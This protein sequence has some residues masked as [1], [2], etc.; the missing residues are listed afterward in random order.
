MAR[1]QECHFDFLSR[2]CFV[3]SH[4]LI[5]ISPK[6]NC[7]PQRIK[8]NWHRDLPE[9]TPSISSMPA[10]SL[11]SLKAACLANMGL[12]GREKGRTIHK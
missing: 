4:H 5:D 12:A 8:L 2:T 1:L 6:L 11:R 10:S 7:Y 3:K 9:F